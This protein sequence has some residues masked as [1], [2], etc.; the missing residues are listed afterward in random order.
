MTKMVYLAEYQ[1]KAVVVSIRNKNNK[2]RWGDFK[3]NIENLKK[4]QNIGGDGDNFNSENKAITLIGSCNDRILVTEYHKRGTLKELLANEEE[5]KQNFSTLPDRLNLLLEYVKSINF[6]HTF[7]SSPRVYCDSNK[8]DGTTKQFLLTDNNKLVMSDM[9]DIPLVKAEN[10]DKA[11]ASCKHPEFLYNRQDILSEGFLAPEQ[12]FGENQGQKFILGKDVAPKIDERSDIYKIADVAAHILLGGGNFDNPNTSIRRSSN[13]N[14]NN[15][16]RSSL[17][18]QAYNVLYESD[19]R[20][21]NLLK[22]CRS[23]LPENRPSSE[24]LINAIESVIESYQVEQS[25]EE[26]SFDLL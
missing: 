17:E 16:K 10:G 18:E 23:E 1:G 19:H 5:Y 24:R 21:S 22:A 20:L 3:E 4:M 2:D 15:Q 25:L 12:K 26:S 6:I 14:D 11:S 9:D 8:L 13:I 7:D